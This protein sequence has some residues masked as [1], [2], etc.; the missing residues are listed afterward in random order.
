MF[1]FKKLIEIIKN[2]KNNSSHIEN[3][4]SIGHIYFCNKVTEYVLK[5]LQIFNNYILHYFIFTH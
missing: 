2:V 3:N 4:Y 1:E 5:K